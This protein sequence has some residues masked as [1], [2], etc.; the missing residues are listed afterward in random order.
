L[1]ADAAMMQDESDD[2]PTGKVRLLTL[3][4]IDRRTSAAGKTLALRD[5]LLGDLGGADA[6]TIAEAQLVQR[7]A[8]LGAM[9]EDN[10]V[11]WLRGEPIEL[12]DYLATVNAQRRTLATVEL[13]RR[14]RDVTPS[15][16]EYINRTERNGA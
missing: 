15:L 11:R 9:L 3:A 12:A 7:S 16:T 8:V 1:P 6:V 5:R 13:G 2:K 14:A 4:D 10:E